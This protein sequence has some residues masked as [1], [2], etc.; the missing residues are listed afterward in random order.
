MRIKTIEKNNKN[1]DFF[2]ENNSVCVTLPYKSAASESNLIPEIR[3]ING[4]IVSISAMG[5]K[6][7]MD[8]PFK[9]L[10]G[11]LIDLFLKKDFIFSNFHTSYN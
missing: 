2:C 9:N 10:N 4:T 6:K 8:F 7:S 5:K 1:E 3:T 11:K